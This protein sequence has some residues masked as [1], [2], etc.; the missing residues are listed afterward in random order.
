MRKVSLF[1]TFLAII[2][3]LGGCGEDTTSLS[4]NSDDTTDDGVI[5]YSPSNQE[6]SQVYD[7]NSGAYYEIFVYSF[8]DS[9]NDGIGDL[10]G[11][12]EKLPYLKELGI[13]GIWLCPIMTSNSYHK[14]DVIDYYN[15]D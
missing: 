3:L 12:K 9:N 5:D 10:N 2:G 8:Y 13:S 7:N 1:I 6:I 15:I 11:V 14:Y 4:L